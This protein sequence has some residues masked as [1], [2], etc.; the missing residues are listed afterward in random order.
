MTR[1][2]RRALF[3]TGSAAALLAAVGVS[4][5]AS[6]VRGGHLRVALSGGNRAESW[7]DQP[8]G[9][10]LQ[11]VRNTVFESLTEIGSDGTLQP[12]LAEEWA[13]PDHGKT[14]QLALR[15][16]IT[17]HDGQALTAAD[18]VASLSHH[19]DIHQV[20][21]KGAHG[22]EITLSAPDAGFPFRLADGSMSIFSADELATGKMPRLGTG[23]Y[24]IKR[25]DAGRSFLGERVA[26]HRKDGTAG[27][28]DTVELVAMSDES[29]RA[30]A[31]RDGYVDATDLHQA[32]DLSGR[33]DVKL[34]TEAGIVRAALRTTIT[35]APRVGPHPLDSMRF[36]T[37]WWMTA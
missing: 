23:V 31:V 25:F 11:A 18:V 9:S 14:W 28:F 24:R 26:Q 27:W 32:Y 37:R 12:G 8:G 6:P 22:V 1:L 36:A 35:H 4:A 30:E 3:T 10:F 29:V 13:T 19:D 7:T 5:Q 20:I 15:S 16:D 21:A 17:F 34:L 2:D 33:E